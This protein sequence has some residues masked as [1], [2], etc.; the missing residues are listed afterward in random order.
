MFRVY[1][2]LSLLDFSCILQTVAL[3]DLRNLRLKLH[4]FESHKDEIFQVCSVS[5]FHL[6]IRSLSFNMIIHFLGAM[7]AS[8]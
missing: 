8:Q 2:G 5:F 4:S 1:L 7:V 6:M 3:W